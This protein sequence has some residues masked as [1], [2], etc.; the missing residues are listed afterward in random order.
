MLDFLVK[1]YCFAW[2]MRQLCTTV[3]ISIVLVI[4]SFDF[5][6]F[7]VIRYDWITFIYITLYKKIF[8]KKK[9]FNN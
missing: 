4:N 2:F 9:S 8:S 6:I 3:D 5:I 1:A 7:N